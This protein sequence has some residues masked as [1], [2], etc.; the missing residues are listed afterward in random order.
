MRRVEFESVRGPFKYN[1]NGIPIQDFFKREVV[2][3]PDGKLWIKTVGV[4]VKDSKDPFW[5]ECP[6]ASRL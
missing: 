5:Q 6:D 1:V 2:K 3:N 4:A